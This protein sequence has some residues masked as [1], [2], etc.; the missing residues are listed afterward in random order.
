MVSK[1]AQIQR[2]EFLRKMRDNARNKS[3]QRI[4][5]WQF[6]KDSMSHVMFLRDFVTPYLSSVYKCII[7]QSGELNLTVDTIR[8]F[9]NL[10]EVIFARVLK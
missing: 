10:P 8:F 5:V 2:E 4:T 1:A 6:N 9:F 7:E 3:L